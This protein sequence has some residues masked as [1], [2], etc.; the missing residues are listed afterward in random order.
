MLRKSAAIIIGGDMPKKINNEKERSVSLSSMPYQINQLAKLANVS[1]RTLHYY[2]EIGLL[3]PSR[4]AKN[5]YRYYEKP[6]LL[7]LQQILFYR[8]LDFPLEEIKKILDSPDFNILDALHEQKRLLILKGKKINKIIFTINKT[9][10][11]MNKNNNMP[12]EELYDPFK[13]NDVKKYQ[14]EAKLRWGDTQA[15]KESMAK[16]K[17]MTK[18]KMAKLKE[19]SRAFTQK[20]AES[21]DKGPDNK[22]VQAL[23][24]EHYKS[25][26]FFYDCP[27]EM[28]R[29]LGRM[30]V[31]DPRFAA[32]YD[33][34]RPGLANFMREAIEIFCQDKFHS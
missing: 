23:I 27:Y 2:D 9:I 11:H 3:K 29:N 16:V 28:Y 30:Y 31:N 26:C 12:D 34:F 22:E 24:A 19:D 6:E 5:G 8:E 20:L 15:Y 4:V 32:Y 25:I 13:D 33:K 17:T 1:V 7:R 21:M 18:A 10:N 14:P